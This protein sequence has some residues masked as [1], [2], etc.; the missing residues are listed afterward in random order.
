MGLLVRLNGPLF[1]GLGSRPK[2]NSNSPARTKQCPDSR[3]LHLERPAAGPK[4]LTSHNV[5]TSNAALTLRK[6][7]IN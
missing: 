2:T 3:A 1:M 4:K 5:I 7:L 6:M